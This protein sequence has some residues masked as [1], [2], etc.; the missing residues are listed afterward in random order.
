[1]IGKDAKKGGESRIK[2]IALQPERSRI[3]GDLHVN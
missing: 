2:D 3:R 1:M